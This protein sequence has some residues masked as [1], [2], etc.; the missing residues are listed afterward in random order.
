M[1]S[2]DASLFLNI[3]NLSVD[4]EKEL[5][6]CGGIRFVGTVFSYLIPAA[7]SRTEIC[8]EQSQHTG[9]LCYC[10]CGQ[11]RDVS[12]REYEGLHTYGKPA[13][14]RA[15]AGPEWRSIARQN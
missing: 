14:S 4:G 5:N 8:E 10:R 3:F 7:V 12:K 13:S 9:T 6:L 15:R 11:W 1:F 2:T